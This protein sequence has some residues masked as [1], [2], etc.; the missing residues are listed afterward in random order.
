RPACPAPGSRASKSRPDRTRCASAGRGAPRGCTSSAQVRASRT[1]CTRSP[2]RSKFLPDAH[3]AH[4]SPDSPR[5]FRV[6]GD[7]HPAAVAADEHRLPRARSGARA[8]RDRR[9]VGLGHHPAP[10]G[11]RRG[12]PAVHPRPRVLSAAHARHAAGGFRFRHRPGR[13]HRLRVRGARTSARH[14]LARRRRAGRG[15]RHEL[16]H[17][18]LRELFTL[19]VLLVVLSSAWV[20]HIAGLSF[21]LGAFLSGMMLAETE[22]RHQIEA[23]IRPFRDLLLGLFF[24]S[25]G[26]LL[27]MRLL[28]RP[29]ELAIVLAMLLTLV[30]LKA[31]IGALV[32]RPFTTTD[33]KALRTGIVIAIGGE[34]GV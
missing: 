26:M 30:I 3:A 15:R 8:A 17:S 12:V 34:F 22:Y 5:G 2:A 4:R 21:A 33:F 32:T 29:S 18:R 19:A 9:A 24:I 10:G 6:P 13:R 31:G 14:P 16:A 23:V 27:D 28:T 20:S 11:A 1:G 25:V 7:T